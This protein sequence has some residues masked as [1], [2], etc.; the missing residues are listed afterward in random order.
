[1]IIKFILKLLS[2]IVLLIEYKSY[3]FL[4][5]TFDLFVGR[6]ALSANVNKC[7]S[8]KESQ[9]LVNETPLTE[10]WCRIVFVTKRWILINASRRSTR[11]IITVHCFLRR[12]R[13]VKATIWSFNSFGSCSSFRSIACAFNAAIRIFWPISP[14]TVNWRI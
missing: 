12:S 6:A 11:S 5:T 14:S 1:M 4:S 13:A 8:T 3:L 2:S 10:P 7:F 9:G